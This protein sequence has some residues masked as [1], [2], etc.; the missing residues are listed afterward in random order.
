MRGGGCEGREREAYTGC[1]EGCACAFFVVVPSD[2][3]VRVRVGDVG[4]S[5]GLCFVSLAVGVGS[6]AVMW[7]GS[8]K[9]PQGYERCTS[10]PPS[11]VCACMPRECGVAVIR[12]GVTWRGLRCCMVPTPLSPNLM[13]SP[14]QLECMSAPLVPFSAKSMS[15]AA[16]GAVEAAS[17]VIVKRQQDAYVHPPR[18]LCFVPLTS[19]APALSSGTHMCAYICG[20]EVCV[21]MLS[22]VAGST[23]T[24]CRR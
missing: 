17:D 4:G 3:T 21:R 19:H 22:R 2:G 7:S 11:S 13:P 23:D 6:A 12:V 16:I 14:V 5:K 8:G 18:A 15:M 10:R 1:C 24:E 9:W 20:C